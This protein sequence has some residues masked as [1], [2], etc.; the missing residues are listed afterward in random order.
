MLKTAKWPALLWFLISLPGCGDTVSPS[1]VFERE[2]GAKLLFRFEHPDT[3][4]SV[5]FWPEKEVLVTGCWDD[6]IRVWNIRTGKPDREWKAQ[7]GGITALAASREGMLA[8]GGSDCSVRVWDGLKSTKV[9]QFETRE[10]ANSLA[11]S[12]AEGLLSCTAWFSVYLWDL[13]KR[14]P[15]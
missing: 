9:A 13:P 6:S 2:Q 4:C 10:V 5:L 11:F 15:I 1:T 8:S 3:V 12:P 7:Q 14:Q